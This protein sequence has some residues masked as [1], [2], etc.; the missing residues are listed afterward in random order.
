VDH[1]NCRV[2][3]A[4]LYE[5][6]SNSKQGVVIVTGADG[7][8]GGEVCRLLNNLRD[9]IFATDVDPGQSN[10]LLRIA[11]ASSKLARETLCLCKFQERS[12][13]VFFRSATYRNGSGYP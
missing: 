12:W 8:I 10:W 3:L 5:M 11:A 7:H 9:Q 4:E 2:S 6:A 13:I 1:E